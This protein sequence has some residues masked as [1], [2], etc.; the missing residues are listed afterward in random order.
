MVSSLLTT[1]QHAFRRPVATDAEVTRKVRRLAAVLFDMDGTLLDSAE[2]IIVAFRQTCRELLGRDVD[3]ATVLREWA[4]PIRQRFHSLAPDRDQEL[5]QEYSRRYLAM[6]DR[7]ARLFPGVSRALQA[8]LDRRYPMAIV[9]SKRRVTTQA[10]VN[11]FHL[12]RWCSIIVTDEDTRRHKPDPEPVRTAA[13]R[14]GVAPAETLM[15]GDTPFDIDAGR[16]AGAVTAGALWGTVDPA[17]LRAHHPDH[18]FARPE[19][20]LTLC[21]PRG[22]MLPAIGEQ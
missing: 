12:G 16:D 14:L 17:A 2:L 9:T 7:Y 11:A 1:G 5:A 21:P 18:M 8:L 19:D 20:V 15:V 22:E 4:R 13:E 10:A 6:H 3:R